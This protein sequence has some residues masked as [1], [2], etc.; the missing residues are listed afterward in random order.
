MGS[1][2]LDFDH[3][4]QNDIENYISNDKNNEREIAESLKRDNF[5]SKEFATEIIEAKSCFDLINAKITCAL[6]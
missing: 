5:N 2:K 1:L 4:Y 6:P 3:Q